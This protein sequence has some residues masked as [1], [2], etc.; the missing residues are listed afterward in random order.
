MQSG[1]CG[2]TPLS[3][4][5]NPHFRDSEVEAVEGF[6]V[7]QHPCQERISSYLQK[8]HLIIS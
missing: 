5:P 4:H 8:R 3:L 2:S 1:T 6:P 7:V